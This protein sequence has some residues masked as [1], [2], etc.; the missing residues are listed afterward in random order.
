VCARVRP[1][2]PAY[3]R[4]L[5]LGCG[6]VGA[7]QTQ[8]QTVNAFA[9]P[10]A[11]TCSVSGLGW[12]FWLV[13]PAWVWQKTTRPP[14]TKTAHIRVPFFVRGRGVPPKS[15]WDPLTFLPVPTANKRYGD[16]PFKVP[17]R[18]ATILD[19][20]PKRGLTA[21]PYACFNVRI[22]TRMKNDKWSR[23]TT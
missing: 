23:S 13:V 12:W 1:F 15:R 4:G 22:H 5:R 19:P 3:V 18:R 6:G 2:S 20:V 16:M 9:F 14:T 8:R 21:Y 10:S 11:R 7:S 17:L